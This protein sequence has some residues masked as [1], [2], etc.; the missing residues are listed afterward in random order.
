M[1]CMGSLSIS[2]RAEVGGPFDRQIRLWGAV[3][4][5]LIQPVRRGGGG[6]GG[7]GGVCMF[8]VILNSLTVSPRT[9]LISDT[10]ITY[11]HRGRRL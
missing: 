11:G 9:S 3:C 6:G 5:W 4:L 1:Y 8:L 2:G 10:I 7:E